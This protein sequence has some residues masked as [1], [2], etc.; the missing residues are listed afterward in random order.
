MTNPPIPAAQYVRMSTE[1]QKYSINNQEAVI[2]EYAQQNGYRIVQT[3]SDPGISGLDLK[4]RPGLKSLLKTVV[5]GSAGFQTILVLDVSRWGRFQD[6]DESAYYEFLCRQSGVR[7]QYCAEPFANDQSAYSNLVKAIKR[8]M[9]AEYSREL[10]SKVFRGQA[11]L[12]SLGY[13]QGGAPQIGLRRLLIGQEGNP[14]QLLGSGER[15]SLMTDRVLLVPGP[16]PEI[17]FVR[18]LFERFCEGQTIAQIAL[19]L[20]RHRRYGRRWTASSILNLL[21]NPQYVGVYVYNRTS[22]KLKS[23]RIVNPPSQW[24]RKPGALEPIIPPA[25]FE[26]AQKKLEGF[27]VNLSN[28]ELLSRL[29]NLLSEKGFLTA[30]LIGQSQNLPAASTYAHR[31]GDLP[32]AFRLIGF[33]TSG[34]GLSKRRLLANLRQEAWEAL[35]QNLRENGVHLRQLSTEPYNIHANGMPLMHF[36]LALP[37]NSGGSGPVWQI[38]PPRPSAIGRSVIAMMSHD[39]KVIEYVIS[40]RLRKTP[41]KRFLMTLPMLASTSLA[42]F[43]TPPEFATAL[44]STGYLGT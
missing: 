8:T 30:R 20:R 22:T 32:A 41:V 15:K 37:V 42:R 4:H 18:H 36:V 27:T 35:K 2:A 26:G 16:Q 31:F 24:I 17:R 1:D 11:R 44:R 9:A 5:S 10:G 28:E 19:D 7:I 3:F 38:R 34:Q 13:K 6:I 23:G 40:G 21:R 25:L 33:N 43:K 39:D 14:K 29:R 12:A